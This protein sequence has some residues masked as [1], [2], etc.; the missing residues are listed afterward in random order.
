MPR[1]RLNRILIK[2]DAHEC[3]LRYLRGIENLLVLENGAGRSPVYPSSRTMTKVKSKTRRDYAEATAE[4]WDPWR[5]F[6]LSTYRNG[7]RMLRRILVLVRF[8]VRILFQFQCGTRIDSTA[9]FPTHV[10]SDQQLF[11][12]RR[13]SQRIALERYHSRQD[14]TPIRYRYLS[15]CISSSDRVLNSEG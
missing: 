11:C 13:R 8:R 3:F 12:S 9:Q 14:R 2:Q 10:R 7:Y 5:G 4:L 6:S 1:D 15:V